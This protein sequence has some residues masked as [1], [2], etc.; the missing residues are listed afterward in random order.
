MHFTHSNNIIIT[1]LS[2]KSSTVSGP[3]NTFHFH[4]D[5]KEDRVANKES[6]VDQ[7]LSRVLSIL[8]QA[9]RGH[10]DVVGS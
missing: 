7:T 10:F 9:T 8:V 1:L 4:A 5:H 6:D 2:L 3:G